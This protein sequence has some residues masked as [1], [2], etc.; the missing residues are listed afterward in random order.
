MKPELRPI[1]RSRL[2]K[3]TLKSIACFWLA[4]VIIAS[5]TQFWIEYRR[6]RHDLLNTFNEIRQRYVAK[7]SSSV[8]GA[9]EQQVQLNLEEVFYLEGIVYAA[10][11][12]EKGFHVHVGT[13]PENP[14]LSEIFA[15]EYAKPDGVVQ[16][17]GTLKV[18]SRA[19]RAFNWFLSHTA[20][21][22]CG[23]M[24]GI[25]LILLPLLLYTYRALLR[26]I[27]S[28]T[29][30]V[31][32]IN[33]DSLEHH[34]PTQP[35]HTSVRTPTEIQELDQCFENMLARLAQTVQ[36]REQSVIHLRN[37]EERLRKVF[38]S[39]MMGMFYWN[40]CGGI[41]AANQT[42]LDMV[43]Y[44]RED[45]EAGR[46]NWS[47]M[48]PKEYAER[49]ATAVAE[50]H[51]C[52]VVAPFEKEYFRKDGTRLPVLLGCVVLEPE[53]QR[54]V[55]FVLD[56]SERNSAEEEQRKSKALLDATGRMARV[57]GWELD[58]DTLEVRWT[59]EIHRIHEVPLDYMPPLQEAINYYHPDDQERLSQAI[60]RA[61]ERGEPYDEEIR[62]ITA[63]GTHLWTRTM[64]QPQIVNGNVVRLTGTFQDITERKLAEEERKK[65][66]AQLTQAQ[67]MESVGRLAGGVA[68]DFNNM[69]NVI[70][71]HVELAL[72]G[73]SAE[74]PLCSDLEEIKKAAERS[75][76]LTCQL[77]AFARRQTVA[78]QVLNLNETIEPMLTML[79]RLIGEDI[80]LLW[81]PAERL[82]PVRI[83]R[84]Q[85]DQL[86]ANLVVNARDAIDGVG[87]VTIETE[88]VEFD[89]DYC[90]THAGFDPGEYVLLAVSDDGR[91][92]DEETQTQIFEPF[93]TTKGVREGT[94]LGLA[95]VYGIVKQ[96]QGFINCSSEPGQGTTFRIYLR[97]YAAGQAGQAP[98]G[99]EAALPAHGHETVLLVEDE[100]AIL[101]LG[102]R[103][104]E[105]LGYQ[106]LAASTPGK[107]IRL[108][109]EH[110]GEI[111][112][113]ITDVVM[114]E[115]NGRDLAKRLLSLYPNLKRLFMS[116]YTADVIA[117]H[118]VLEEGVHFLQKPFSMKQL[119][120]DVREALEQD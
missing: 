11:D 78:P 116:G 98:E 35:G 60:K 106:V 69:L 2:S 37:T 23:S 102:T 83:D 3:A 99:A 52:G 24:F 29:E 77:L 22:F 49:D 16:P 92:M 117:H 8:Y 114:P 26:P 1:L 31:R 101:A 9:E 7:L 47:K 32:S 10:V 25:G 96:N 70:L 51:Q 14:E 40:L 57:G 12:D 66:Q 43:G 38:E 62:F 53:Q 28:V 75:A 82:K 61:L 111:Q 30:K 105:R 84:S 118:G 42:F 54:G 27:V 89:E 74:N 19:P 67:K 81:Q 41:T 71:G 48:T 4:F 18:D 20:P 15:L 103:I 80:D 50:L 63:K 59:E 55:S 97:V 56:V 39:S 6:D 87:K 86:L 79:G 58:A 95:T 120:I 110:S 115:M 13:R 113:L 90:A 73:L 104:L 21:I 64:C 91:G 68:H 5:L 65:L 100:S 109:E 72:E 46:M 108:A 88:Q 93:F 119:E 17:L 107:A 34:W 76:N 94:G 44:T 33:I 112:L 85:I 36:E 45:L